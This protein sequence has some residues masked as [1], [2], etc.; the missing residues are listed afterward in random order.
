MHVVVTIT[1]GFMFAIV[2]FVVVI[3]G[4]LYGGTGKHQYE[5][6]LDKLLSKPALEVGLLSNFTSVHVLTPQ[7]Q[8][9]ITVIVG[10]PA[11]GLVKMSLL[12]QY[13]LLFNV[14]RYIRISVWIA[15]VMFGVFYVT[16]TIVAFV[17]NSP[18]GGE[19]LLHTIVSWHYLKFAEFAIPTGV[20]GMV[21][22][23]FLFFLPMPAVW[24]LHLNMSRKIG[25]ML[26]FATGGV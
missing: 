11:L 13:Y 22:D 1:A 8:S 26:V 9:Y 6:G 10:T 7:Q 12:I 3:R 19:S 16:V 25:I 5:L 14:R 24:N 2:H 21:F 15:G 20:I 23:W 4:S 17:L 18:W